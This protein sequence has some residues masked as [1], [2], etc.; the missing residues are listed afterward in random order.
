MK[1]TLVYIGLSLLV[2][3]GVGYS[4]DLSG[5]TKG[6]TPIGGGIGKIDSFESLTKDQAL[7]NTLT[8]LCSRYAWR[9]TGL[10]RDSEGNLNYG[11][12]VCSQTAELNPNYPDCKGKGGGVVFVDPTGQERTADD[13]EIAQ[14]ME[15]LQADARCEE[16]G[17][18]KK[19]SECDGG[20]DILVCPFDKNS[21]YQ[22]KRVVCK[23][24]C[25]A[26]PLWKEDNKYYHRNA[27][28]MKV[29]AEFK[30][31]YIENGSDLTQALDSCVSDNGVTY[32]RIKKC[33]TTPVSGVVP[34]YYNDICMVGCTAS[35]YPYT[36]HPGSYRGTVELCQDAE[37][38]HFG[39][40]ACNDGYSGPSNGK[41]SLTTCS[42]SSYPYRS[43]PSE[44]RGTLSVCHSQSGDVYRYQSCNEGYTKVNGLCQKKCKATNC[45]KTIKTVKSADESITISYDDYHCDL[46]ADC[47]VGDELVNNSNQ[48]MGYIAH[49][50]RD[51]NDHHIAIEQYGIEKMR[52][53][54]DSF[55]WCVRKADKCCGGDGTTANDELAGLALSK[56]IKEKFPQKSL[57]QEDA[58][59]TFD[60]LEMTKIAWYFIQNEKQ[61]SNGANNCFSTGTSLYGI[62]ETINKAFKNCDAEYC[63]AGQKYISSAGENVLIDEGRDILSPLVYAITDNNNKQTM[64]I[65]QGGSNNY[66]T[67]GG[68]IQEYGKWMITADTNCDAEGTDNCPKVVTLLSF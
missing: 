63:A 42:N 59:T 39:Y 54:H 22:D 67:T 66:Q 35:K 38:D 33:K 1:K 37:G 29:E 53:T 45:Q 7:K 30:T 50:A 34:I 16:Y 68:Q 60:G 4:A 65:V 41:C 18:T 28:G 15:R 61:V 40:I 2:M 5:M 24:N 46:P 48:T 23:K 51:A 19:Q 8:D 44:E 57:S 25:R 26:F 58:Y 13:D 62:N 9:C 27:S 10:T 36:E 55:Y 31:A 64:S 14:M 32:Y 43:K 17:Y 47:M 52:Y 6:K 21:N 49:I 20:D 56:K 11:R 3:M 12:V